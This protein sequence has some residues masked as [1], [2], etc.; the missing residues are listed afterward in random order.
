VMGAL[1][2]LSLLLKLKVQRAHSGCPPNRS[3]ELSHARNNRTRTVQACKF[4]LDP[5]TQGGVV[6]RERCVMAVG[7]ATFSSVQ[8]NGDVNGVVALRGERGEAAGR[9]G[10]AEVAFLRCAR[11]SAV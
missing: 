2:L 4:D 9:H 11:N 7:M 8:F 1:L 5:T 10:K 3:T 6:R